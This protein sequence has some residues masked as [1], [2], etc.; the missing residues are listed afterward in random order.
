MTMTE[1]VLRSCSSPLYEIAAVSRSGCSGHRNADVFLC[2][3]ALNLLAIADGLGAST[4]PAEASRL[5]VE[6][7]R[8]DLLS[9]PVNAIHP[10]A[11]D[12]LKA[13]FERCNAVL[14]EKSEPYERGWLTTLTAALVGPTNL[15][16]AHCGDSRAYLWRPGGF[17]QLTRDHTMVADLVS[18]GVMRH[19]DANEHP[20]R[21]V[22][23]SCLGLQRQVRIDVVTAEV[24]SGHILLLCSDGI[25]GVLTPSAIA[26][27]LKRSK[28]AETI[29]TRLIET[30]VANGTE[31]DATGIVARRR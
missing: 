7:L 30:A 15:V 19:D 5:A 28:S 26:Q 17:G 21:H 16:I 24:Q 3:D 18:A 27:C 4:A 6:T 8:E 1:T 9:R 23:S 2:D 13:A 31:D 10:T 22:L 14:F 25:S 12:R 20:R 29:A 11:S